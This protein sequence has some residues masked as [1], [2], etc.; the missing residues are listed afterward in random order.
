MPKYL[1]QANYVGEGLKGLLK[2]G[3]SSRRAVVEKALG[4]VGGRIEAFYYA[5]GDTDVFVITDM[6]DNIT[7]AAVSLIV[8]AP[9]TVS[10]KITVLLTPEEID[11]ATKV[12]ATYRAPGQ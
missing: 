7:A 8:N 3:G 11:A 10:A 4:S 2:E 5:F 12:T 1:I 6:P 9:G